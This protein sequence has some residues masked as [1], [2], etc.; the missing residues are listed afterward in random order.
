M[1]F[2]WGIR[3]DGPMDLVKEELERRQIPHL[4]FDHKRSWDT[5]VQIHYSPSVKGEIACDGLH[6]ALEKVQAAYFRPYDFRM[7]PDYH[8]GPNDWSNPEA[9]H[10]MNLED[11][12][13]S[14]AETAPCLVLNKASK[15]LSNNSKPY[16]LE[17]IKAVGLSVPETILTT[18]PEFVEHFMDQYDDVIYKSISGT[19]SIVSKLGPEKQR[20]LNKVKWCP[21]QFQNY[22]EGY[23]CRVHV[24]NDRVFGHRILSEADDYRYDNEGIEAT[25]LPGEIHDKCIELSHKLELPLCG[26]DFMV[27]KEN[28]W[29]CFEVNPSPAYSYYQKQTGQNI[30]SAIVD[31]MLHY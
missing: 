27:T 24:V 10:V 21:T 11:I 6:L 17:V 16:Q 18:S 3:G 20:N 23:N 9:S 4:F 7:Y 12:L 15:M 28:E 31:Y 13:W 22:I 29:V 5:Q 1:I 25:D 2:L 14:W 8:Y 19:R 26:I 30:S